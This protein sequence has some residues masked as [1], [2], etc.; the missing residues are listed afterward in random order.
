MVSIV[1]LTKTAIDHFLHEKDG[2]QDIRWDDQIRGFGV[3][4]YPSNRKTFVLSYRS[5]GRKHIMQLGPYGVLTLDQARDR[6][7][8]ELVRIME[9]E[10]P[11]EEKRRLS[12]SATMEVLCEAY[13]TRHAMVHKKSWRDDDSHIRL[14][15]IP[16]LGSL[17]VISVQR[18]D[19]AKLHQEIGKSKPTRANRVLATL[20]HMFELAKLWG[21]LEEGAPNPA[22]RIQKYSEK[23]RDRW[24]TQEELPALARA[25]D[26][27]ENI[28]A[29]HYFWLLILTGA[30]KSELL[31]AKW[32]DVDTEAGQLKFPETKRG[33]AH[34]IPLTGPVLAVLGQIPKLEGNPYLFPGEGKEGHMINVT[35]PWARIRKAAGIEDINIHDL[36][37]TVGS[38]LAQGGNSLH[39]IGKVLGHSNQST[40]AIYSRFGQD[41]VRQA[42]DDH[43][44]RLMV[45][46]G[47]LPPAEVKELN[48][49]Q[50]RK[51][52][53]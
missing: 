13:L 46:A 25:I 31:Q 51:A 42:M 1:K 20:S 6:A 52:K 4:V 22:R 48:P 2:G 40:T 24:V 30:R 16:A 9:G 3:R 18:S 41:S 50:K 49:Q 12:Q 33:Q 36:R 28:Y 8:R 43:G 38:W 26:E 32:E 15:I 53:T 34:Y 23:S 44:R 45:A 29:R 17:P 14:H 11:L 19:V 35:K 10:D 47:K 21:Y 5:M 27:E 7:K 39:L 37:R